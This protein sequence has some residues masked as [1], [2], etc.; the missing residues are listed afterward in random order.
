MSLW[1]VIL[2]PAAILFILVLCF[3]LYVS[4]SGLPWNVRRRILRNLAVF[5]AASILQLAMLIFGQ[6]LAVS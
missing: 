5:L 6:F 1:N 3:A 4:Q 2:I